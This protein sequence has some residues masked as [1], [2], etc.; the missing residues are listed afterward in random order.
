[1]SDIKY[2]R[3]F[4]WMVRFLKDVRRRRISPDTRKRR[5]AVKRYSSGRTAVAM[6]PERWLAG[7]YR[8]I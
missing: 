6:F 4:L 2:S 8:Q 7:N 1:M 3:T 5:A